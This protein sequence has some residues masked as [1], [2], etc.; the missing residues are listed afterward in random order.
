M[1][2]QQLKKLLEQLHQEL[3]QTESV[4]EETLS[5]V[6]E[7]DKDIHKLVAPTQRDED[8][9]SVLERSRELKTQFAANHP[10][11]ERF[12]SQIMDT[13]AKIGI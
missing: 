7:L 5:Q 8:M 4:S 12:L 10:E 2:E 11:A 6:R 3:E 13:L 9:D 1:P